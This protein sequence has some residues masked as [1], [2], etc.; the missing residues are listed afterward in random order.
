MM[1]RLVLIALFIIAVLAS[2]CAAYGESH[3]SLD[4]KRG[5]CRVHLR[6][7]LLLPSS[8]LREPAQRLQQ[9]LPGQV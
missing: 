8:C 3:R 2:I 6:G 7:R 1:Q 9:I 4:E 5:G